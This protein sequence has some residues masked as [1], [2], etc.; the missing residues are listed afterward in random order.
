VTNKKAAAKIGL[1]ARKLKDGTIKKKGIGIKSPYSQKELCKK[2]KNQFGGKWNAKKEMWVYPL[3]LDVVKYAK[4]VWK[5]NDYNIGMSDLLQDWYEQ[6]KQKKEQIISEKNKDDIS[7]AELDT[8]L[9]ET[10]Y[11][12]QRIGT[13]FLT[14]SEGAILADDMGLGK[15]IQSLAA[16]D[17]LDA[18][19]I[20]VVCP[21]SLK[22]NWANEIEKWLGDWTY[23]VVAGNKED[24]IEALQKE[25]DFYI[26]N[27][28]SIRQKSRAKVDREWTKVNNP[29]F[30]MLHKQDWDV[31]IFDEAHRIKNRKSQQTK[32]AYRLVKKAEKVYHLTG[33]PIMNSPDEIWSLLHSLDRQKY[34]SFWNF[35]FRYCNVYDNG[36]GKDIG[37]VK[38][39]KEFREMLKPYMLRRMKEQVIEDM[40]ELTIKQQWIELE[41]QQRKYYQQMRKRMVTEFSNMEKVTA[42]III[43]KIMR[44][45]QIAV[46]PELLAE[47]DYKSAKIDALM[48]IIEGAGEQKVVV[49]TQF[50][51]A[52]ELVK[53]LLRDKGI[54]S[55]ILHGGIDE[56]DRQKAIDSFQ[57]N[58][59]TKVFIATIKAG[60][61]GINLTEGSI[62]VFLDKDWT[63]AN[64]NQAIDRLHRIGQESN[65]TVIE[66][67]A[68][69]TI[70]EYI[71]GM[72]EKKQE[73]FDSV[74]DGKMTG[75]ELLLNLNMNK[76]VKRT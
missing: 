57:N 6:E 62:A 40:P 54:K 46:S 20:L 28:A 19:N 13:N 42:S 10:L 70:E 22:L 68:K 7:V 1:H 75:K 53:L 29:I 64:N 51:K 15:T 61:V 66:L 3:E 73:M 12:Y 49:F 41:G 23:S 48:D 71:E 5:Q 14:V 67:L 38:N 76:D 59:D 58:K 18:E 74:V 34:S 17:C 21:A 27:Y 8:E 44:L 33:T 72:L 65:V 30:K 25:A 69:D 52:A 35:V 55:G 39:P 31:M 56:E 24:R 11:D 47:G 63:P 9:A 4:E 60:G 37:G 50:Q 26:T 2:V 45:K 32:A 16:I 43:T 36:F